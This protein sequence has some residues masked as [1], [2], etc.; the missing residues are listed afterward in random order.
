[1][2][3]VGKHTY[4]IRED[5]TNKEGKSA[6]GVT[7]SNEEV[8]V[9]VEV[10]DNGDGTLKTEVTYPDS[11]AGVTFTNAYH[12]VGYAPLTGTKKLEGNRSTAIKEGEFTF[13]V[14]ETTAGKEQ[15]EVATGKTLAGTKTSATIQFTPSDTLPEGAPDGTTFSYTQDDIG[16][17]TYEI[18]EVKGKDTMI[19]Y[20]KDAV[21]VTVE[22]T[23]TGTGTLSVEVT[24]PTNTDGTKATGVTFVNT[25][26]IPAPTGIRVDILPYAIMIAIA[27]CLC[28]LLTINKR[29]NRSVRRR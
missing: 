26:R 27:A 15:K 25:Y 23:D 11:A 22:V 12:A 28:M 3:D 14:V 21:T 8:T 9:T 18:T 20:A 7:Y 24:Y 10:S 1:L 4:V 13:S 17:H 29:K 6:A 2:A 5:A 19:D 16:T